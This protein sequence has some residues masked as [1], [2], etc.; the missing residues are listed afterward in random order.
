MS[1]DRTLN[2]EE[3]EC[4]LQDLKFG[5]SS[6]DKDVQTLL[7]RINAILQEENEQAQN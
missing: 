2:E 1:I 7:D 4:L 6:L 3:V 5:F